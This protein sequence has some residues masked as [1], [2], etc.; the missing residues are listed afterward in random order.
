MYPTLVGYIFS[1]QNKNNT[2]KNEH[3]IKNVVCIPT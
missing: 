3:K 2:Y 1:Y